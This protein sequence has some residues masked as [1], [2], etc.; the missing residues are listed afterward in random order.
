MDVVVVAAEPVALVVDDVVHRLAALID[1]PAL[2]IRMPV[3]IDLDGGGLDDL[4]AV[5]LVVEGIVIEE[6]HL[7]D[8][9]LQPFVRRWRE[10]RR[11]EAAREREKA[12]QQQ[13]LRITPVHPISPAPSEGGSI[14]AP[15]RA[16]CT[17]VHP[18]LSPAP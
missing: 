16:W 14:A 4:A 18:A 5:A 13:D 8:G 9:L 7:V 12:P 17:K 11:V 6:D 1:G 2:G 3:G 15:A 10:I